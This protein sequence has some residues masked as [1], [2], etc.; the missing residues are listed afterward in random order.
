MNYPTSSEIDR[1]T[2]LARGAAL[3][4]ALHASLLNGPAQAD[5]QSESMRFQRIALESH[6]PD[7][8]APFYR[9]VLEL[10]VNA[11][12]EGCEIVA[13]E[14]TLAFRKA[15]GD[16]KPFYHFAFNI[17]E[18]KLES[19]MKWAKPK[20]S[21]LHHRKSGGPVVHFRA[22]NAHAV[23]FLDPAGNIVEFI[24]RHTLDNARDGAFSSDDILNVSEIGFVTP[25]VPALESRIQESVGIQTYKSSSP[26]FAPVGN[27]H[28]M[29]ILAKE[30]RVWLPTDDV[31]AKVF[32]ASVIASGIDGSLSGEMEPFTVTRA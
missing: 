29:F 26:V 11:T 10:P 7:A 28:A 32:A 24:A 13:G 31:N 6:V 12:A 3:F 8:L 25:D 27:A 17:P 20:F 5:G 9:D 19:A 1:R 16:A 23:Y 14:S 4:T 30:G 18:N 2:F 22:W 21:L 15:E